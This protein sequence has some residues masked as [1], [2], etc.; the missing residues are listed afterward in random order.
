MESKRCDIEG[1]EAVLP[2]PKIWKATTKVPGMA[3]QVYV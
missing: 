1:D 2:V 3:R